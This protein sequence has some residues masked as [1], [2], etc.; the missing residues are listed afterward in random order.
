MMNSFKKPSKQRGGGVPFSRLN[1][2]SQY[3]KFNKF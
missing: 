3:R 2:N 1:R